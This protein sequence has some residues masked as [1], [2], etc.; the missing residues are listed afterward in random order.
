M[1]KSA[2]LFLLCTLICSS[3]IL[4]ARQ[5]QHLENIKL[6]QAI[7]QIGKY[8][9][10]SFSYNPEILPDVIIKKVVLQGKDIN[11]VLSAV[12]SP[13]QLEFKIANSSIAIYKPKK[14]TLVKQRTAQLIKGYVVDN[15]TKEP[16]PGVNV[17]IAN[18]S[19][20]DATDVNGFFHFRWS[21]SGSYELVLS[22][23]SYKGLVL[24]RNSSDSYEDLVIELAEKVDKLNEVV[25]TASNKEWK[26][27]VEIFKKEFIGTSFN[28]SRCKILNPEVLNFHYDKELDLLRAYSDE[29]ITVKNDALG[30]IVD[31]LLIDF[32]YQNGKVKYSSKA[33]FEELEHPNRIKERKWKKARNNA[34]L[35]SLNHFLQTLIKGD[36]KEEG[37]RIYISDS[38]TDSRIKS[39]AF[40]KKEGYQI[41]ISDSLAIDR[42]ERKA[43]SKELSEKYGSTYTLAFEN[44]LE[45]VYKD[46]ESRR[47]LQYIAKQ[48]SN[49]T[50]NP[51]LEEE[52][53]TFKRETTLLEINS[54]DGFVLIE[55]GML[56]DPAAIVQHG[57]WGWKRNGDLLPINYTPDE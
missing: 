16:I 23:I 32:T 20:G 14:R 9:Q 37:Y 1:A 30:Y 6:S 12:I 19:V 5:S 35:G 51:T 42:R 2:S 50:H 49:Y 8:Y 24:S 15:I 43:F 18:T 22:H 54:P 31:H 17:F 27:R 44:Y 7:S 47:Y 34:Y 46:I 55:N 56:T 13:Y 33:K 39:K 53:F 21:R 29:L 52:N 36:L 28:S 48:S 3:A 4:E 10:V 41:V 45:V 26:K 11:Q 38:L 40:S 57:Y 25:I